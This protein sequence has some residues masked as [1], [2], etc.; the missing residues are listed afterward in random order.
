M[1]LAT[2]AGEQPKRGVVI[3]YHQTLRLV[4]NIA[5]IGA[6]SSGVPAS[7][8]LPITHGS[9][10]RV[11]STCPPPTTRLLR[12]IK[13]FAHLSLGEV[14][15]HRPWAPPVPLLF[16]PILYHGIWEKSIWQYALKIELIFC[17]NCAKC[18]MPRAALEGERAKKVGAYA[19][20]ISPV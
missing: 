3:R 11:F 17:Q 20:T 2:P 19:A 15:A 1:L 12:G 7:D 10:G 18:Q 13:G 9:K 5:A 16:T 4:N 14:S 6:G 8:C